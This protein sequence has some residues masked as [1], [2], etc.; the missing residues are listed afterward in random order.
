MGL[1]LE[2]CERLGIAAEHPDHPSRK[3]PNVK[4]R[5][6]TVNERGQNKTEAAFDRKLEEMKRTGLI[7]D[8]RFEPFKLRLA[9]RTYYSP[10]FAVKR[11]DESLAILEV[12]GFMRDDAAVKLK[13]A[14]EQFA[15]L[16]SFYLVRKNGNGWDIRS[17]DRRGIGT[18]NVENLWI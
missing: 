12:K 1:S 10:D 3:A 9:G 2:Q 15:W 11:N 5:I 16:G 8:Y 18:T 4:V 17:V 13:T 14:A 7:E 6:P